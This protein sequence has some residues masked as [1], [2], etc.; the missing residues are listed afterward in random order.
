MKNNHKRKMPNNLSLHWKACKNKVSK[1][2]LIS[3]TKRK[4]NKMKAYL[5][6]ICRFW[7]LQKFKIK[8]Y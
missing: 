1:D 5:L 6:R 4:L 7:I 2:S 8:T 3:K